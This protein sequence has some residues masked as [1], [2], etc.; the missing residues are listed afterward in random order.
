[1]S[2][3]PEPG[4]APSRR[5][6]PVSPESAP[7]WEATRRGVFLLQWCGACDRPV[8][9][10]RALPRLRHAELVDDLA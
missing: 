6:P 4:V 3:R 10:P 1:M 5:E 2:P 9:Y 8:F 7:F